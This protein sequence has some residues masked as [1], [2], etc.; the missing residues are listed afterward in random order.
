MTTGVSSVRSGPF[1][2][3]AQVHPGI[4]AHG[5]LPGHAIFLALRSRIEQ[6]LKITFLPAPVP[7]LG[8]RA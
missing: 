6:E 2:A 8:R 5:A 4:L 7:A 1:R 3:A